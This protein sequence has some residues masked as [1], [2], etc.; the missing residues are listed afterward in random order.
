MKKHLLF[1]LMLLGLITSAQTSITNGNCKAA[2]K[3]AVNKEVMT[4]LPATTINFY[5][6]S[7]G[8]VKLWFWDFGDGNFSYEQNPMFVFNHPMGGS[9]VKMSPYRTVNL[10]I[11]TADSCKSFYSE[12][13]NI[14]DTVVFV[15][16]S[17]KAGFKYYQTAF[18]SIGGTASFQL[19]DRSEGD[20]LQYLWQFDNGKTST[21][22]EPIVTFDLSRPDRKVCLT[23][24]GRNNCTDMFCDAVY[25]F[26]PYKPVIDTIAPNPVECDTN[27]GYSVNYTIKPFAPAL[28]LDFYSKAWPE[29]TE[30]KWD[31]GDGTTSN[32][33]NPT[34]IF[35]LPLT[36]DS[37]IGFPNPFRN[38]CLTVKTS[39]GC[40]TSSCQTINIYMNQNPVEPVS[41]CRALYK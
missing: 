3:Y 9:T 4:L 13:I 37:L 32:E 29:P 5:D 7:E 24:T 36:Q 41:F 21:E 31:F 40:V 26:D 19:N 27:F 18:D 6:R 2:F 30:W 34:H 11:I 16:P 22:R 35:N 38:V 14:M 23:V 39:T 12:T 33:A 1:A 8:D 20:S 17:C 15:S 10:T 28:V 25:V